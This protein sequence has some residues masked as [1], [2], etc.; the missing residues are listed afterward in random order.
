MTE[1]SEPFSRRFGY[2]SPEPEITI[3]EEAPLWIR[4]WLPQIGIELGMARSELLQIARRLLP[5]A[6]HK[7]NAPMV[8]V[9]LAMRV[10]EWP[11]V[12]DFGEALYVALADQSLYDEAA[13][14]YA[15]R[16]NK[17]FRTRGVGW[18][19]RSGRIEARGSEPFEAVTRE[20]SET[21]E[22]HGRSTAAREIH[23]ALG[24]L[25]RRP[26]PDVSGAIQHA[27][28][29]LEC[30]TRD[31][32]GE[33]SATLGD[34]LKRQDQTL[35]IVPPLDQALIKLWG[36]ASERGRHL[37]EGREPGFEEA[38]LVVVVA[39]AASVYLSKRAVT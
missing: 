12:Y 8:E 34:L 17:L 2:Q 19:M 36:Y 27:M 3:R 38:E 33:S 14:V 32:S 4:Q 20:A 29:A 31:L 22:G 25:S 16:L 1:E 21:L 7:P 39:A 5:E 35:G 37:L 18:Q 15:E 28:A 10:C 13:Q 24:D 11:A 30:V 6:L 26:K 23:E 9:A